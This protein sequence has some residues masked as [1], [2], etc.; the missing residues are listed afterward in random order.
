MTDI[1]MKLGAFA[2]SI[3]TAAYQDLKRTSEWRWAA[4]ARIG[5]T[6]M[7]Q[8]VGRGNDT[9]T[10]TGTVHPIFMNAGIGQIDAL[11]AEADKKT[12]LLLVSGQGDVMGLWVIERVSET[13]NAFYKEGVPKRQQFD[14]SLRYYGDNI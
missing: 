1:M 9:I 14:I 13:Q 11:R 10:L 4:Q 3:S 7:L 12:P 6:D 5:N 8:Y 2:F